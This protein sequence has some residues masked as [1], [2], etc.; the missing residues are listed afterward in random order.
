MSC[1]DALHCWTVGFGPTGFVGILQHTEDGGAHRAERPLPNGMIPLDIVCTGTAHCVAVDPSSAHVTDDGGVTWSTHPLSAG[2]RDV[3]DLTCTDQAHCW[4]VGDGAIGF[5][6][7]GGAT[8]ATQ[9]TT[10]D[11]RY[12]DG[13]ACIDASRCV[14][15]G[16]SL[17]GAS[18]HGD[19][20]DH[21]R[22]A[23][24]DAAAIAGGDQRHQRRRLLHARRVR[25]RCRGR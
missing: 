23:D 18:A 17:S 24:L 9:T 14:A 20:G 21:R 6:G 15:A 10:T 16:Q 25:R 5:S 22:R 3:A 1:T 13:I 2:L 12:P 11:V 8:W 19:R 7:D 4:V